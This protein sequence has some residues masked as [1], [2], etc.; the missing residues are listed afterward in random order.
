MSKFDYQPKTREEALV[1]EE[2]CV[3]KMADEMKSLMPDADIQVYKQDG[4]HWMWSMDGVEMMGIR[5]DPFADLPPRSLHG[6]G[7]TKGE[8]R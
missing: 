1:A 7:N 2:I 4:G 6:E 5:F 3:R 8:T